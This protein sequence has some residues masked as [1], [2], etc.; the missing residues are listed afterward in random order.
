MTQ[1][2]TENKAQPQQS[3]PAQQSQP[4]QRNVILVGQ[5]PTM[6]YALMAMLLFSRE[7][8][9]ITVK[10]RGA[11]ISKAVDITQVLKRR[12]MNGLVDIKG[13]KIGTD[14]LGEAGNVRHVS[15]MEIAVA[16]IKA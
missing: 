9:E 10:A 1:E 11:A 8:N 7:I 6:T 3:Q 4:F 14:I 13:V 16:K 15:T 5:K 12:L 2:N